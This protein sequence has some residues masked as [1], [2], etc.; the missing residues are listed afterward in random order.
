MRHLQRLVVTR[1]HQGMPIFVPAH[2]RLWHGRTTRTGPCALPS[3]PTAVAALP[4][5]GLEDKGEEA[6]AQ[7]EG[8]EETDEFV[9]RGSVVG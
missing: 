4:I 3:G 6:A 8:D 1:H 7:G 2:P 9:A 5:L